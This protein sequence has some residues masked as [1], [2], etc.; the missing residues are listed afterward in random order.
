MLY[1]SPAGVHVG[2][3]GVRLRFRVLTEH[4]APVRRPTAPTELQQLRLS[5]RLLCFTPKTPTIGNTVCMYVLSKG[6]KDP[7][8][9]KYRMGE[10][11]GFVVVDTEVKAVCSHYYDGG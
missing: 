7:N 3:R 5:Y 4:R 1:V 10:A 6:T 9:R 11:I 2:V 8:N